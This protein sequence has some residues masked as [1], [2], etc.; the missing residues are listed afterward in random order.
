MV[1][2]LLIALGIIYNSVRVSFSERAW[3]LA[4]LRVLGF[5]RRQVT[6]V[7]L[8]EVGA[9][10]AWSLIP[11]CLLGLALT[12]LSM[13][14][15]HTETFSFPVVIERATYAKGILTVVMA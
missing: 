13:R 8:M 9:Q 12:H 4:S 2:S 3:E 5:A 7:L 6:A 11:G 10:A 1:A 14:L 15:V